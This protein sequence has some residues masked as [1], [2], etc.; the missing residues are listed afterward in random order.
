MTPYYEHAGVTIYHGD[1]R[2]V[3]PALENNSVDISVTSPP[4]NL[5]KEWSGG[6]PNSNYKS[7]ERLYGEWYPDE[8]AEADY[9]AG[10]KLIVSQLMRICKGSVFYNHKVRYA[11]KRRKTVYHP[12]AWLASFE[13]WCEIIWD[14]GG[15]PGGNSRRLIVSDE[16]IY[17][18]GRPHRWHGSQGHTSVWR[19]PPSSNNGV[20]CSF[21]LELPRRC[22]ALAADP[23]DLVL[24]PYMGSGTTLRAAKDLGCKAV[25]IETEERYCEI[26]AKQLGQEVLGLG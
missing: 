22:I 4:Y 17:Q 3:L 6:G 26:A 14:R 20:P 15:G 1:C 11:W 19:I 13:I 18:L 12:M 2:E 16:R 24:D 10:Q 23:G 5:V 9:Q 8:Q 25:G 21:P 7:L